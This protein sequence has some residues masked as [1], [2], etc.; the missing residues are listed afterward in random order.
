VKIIEV[1]NTIYLYSHKPLAFSR[2]ARLLLEV[3]Q[4]YILESIRTS[5]PCWV[6]I[7][8]YIFSFV[9]ML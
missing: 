6:R 7:L 4:Q 2:F 1:A 3:H 9:R 8:Y 5:S